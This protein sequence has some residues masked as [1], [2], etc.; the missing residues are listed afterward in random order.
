MKLSIP[1]K[2]ELLQEGDKSSGPILGQA[3]VGLLYVGSG[4]TSYLLKGYA[5]QRDTLSS[6]IF[7]IS[8]AVLI[9][10]FQ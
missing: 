4:G 9:S 7:S 8:L 6:L 10:R 2:V 3:L 5:D 1:T